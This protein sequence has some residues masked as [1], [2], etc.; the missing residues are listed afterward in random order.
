VHRF[1]DATDGGASLF[2]VVERSI[3]FS[4]AKRGVTRCFRNCCRRR[5]QYFYT[6]KVTADNRERIFF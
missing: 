6:L 2:R 5:P 1:N 3:V 4:L